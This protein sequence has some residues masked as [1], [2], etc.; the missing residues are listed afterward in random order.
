[1]MMD[2]YFV[3]LK[4]PFGL[5]RQNLERPSGVHCE[6]PSWPFLYCIVR[7]KFNNSVTTLLNDEMLAGLFG[8]VPNGTSMY[9]C[10]ST[11]YLFTGLNLG[12]FRDP[13]RVVDAQ[14]TFY[15]TGAQRDP[16]VIGLEP[17]NILR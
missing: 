4:V 5:Y 15:V 13:K 2:H 6:C 12:P 1:M 14:Y 9:L 10:L 8:G 3:A 11:T 16:H 17:H 7:F